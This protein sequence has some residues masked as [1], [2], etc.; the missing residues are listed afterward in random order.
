MNIL[1]KT[2]LWKQGY[3]SLCKMTKTQV[4]PII[5]KLGAR[6]N[7][8]QVM[9]LHILHMPCHLLQPP[10][11]CKTMYPPPPLH[12]WT[13]NQPPSGYNND[14]TSQLLLNQIISVMELKQ[15]LQ[16]SEMERKMEQI[17]EQIRHHQK[18][19][20]NCRCRDRSCSHTRS[21]H[22]RRD[23]A[24]P[25]NYQQQQRWSQS[26]RW[27]RRSSLWWS[28]W[29]PSTWLQRRPPSSVHNWR[30]HYDIRHIKH[31]D[32]Y[33]TNRSS[34]T[35]SYNWRK[36][37]VPLCEPVH[38]NTTKVLQL[39]SNN[40]IQSNPPLKLPFPEVSNG[41]NQRYHKE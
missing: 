2:K 21:P 37:A 36:P 39:P 6:P 4:M 23:Y 41:L 29:S 5:I 24:A 26:P 20:C 12:G 17:R 32:D 11:N 10:T 9:K 1:Q 25:R 40:S 35:N 18:H 34:T 31:A 19:Q 13:A 8:I 30:G 38:N 22:R 14:Q 27:S 15:K 33:T 3:F 7:P 16:I 28:R